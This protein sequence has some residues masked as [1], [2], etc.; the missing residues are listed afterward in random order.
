V[1]LS[2]GVKFERPLIIILSKFDEWAH[3]LNLEDNGDPWRSQGHMTG[4]DV[5]KIE[6]TSG[7]LREILLKYSPEIVTA[8]EAF[9]KEV[10]YI[11]VSA[12]GNSV[13]FDPS[14]GLPGIR[15]RNI[16]PH[17][18]T[19]PLLYSISRVLPALVPRLVRRSKPR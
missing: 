11:A 9:A 3:L 6:Q 12:L 18:V 19:I 15:P 1:G 16:Q 8:A 2:H 10:T 13:E 14:S 5:E 4:I 7:R 17:W